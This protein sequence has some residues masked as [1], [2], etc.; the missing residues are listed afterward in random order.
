L[1]T[2]ATDFAVGVGWRVEEGT[3]WTVYQVGFDEVSHGIVG[4]HLLLHLLDIFFGLD[5]AFFRFRVNSRLGLLGIGIAIESEE[6][7]IDFSII[8]DVQSEIYLT[9]RIVG[10]DLMEP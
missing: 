9:N 6:I 4:V 7:L 10:I 2:G 5:L 1:K 8:V 3:D